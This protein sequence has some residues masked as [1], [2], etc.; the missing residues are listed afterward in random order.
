ME[1]IHKKKA[2]NT[3]AKMLHDQAEARR[4]MAKEA[5]KR[6]NERIALKKIS[7]HKDE[8]PAHAQESTA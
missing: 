3:R 7:A 5:R 8:A 2:D 4:A 6:R 1:F